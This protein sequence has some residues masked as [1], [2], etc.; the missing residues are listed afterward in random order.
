[1]VCFEQLFLKKDEDGLTDPSSIKDLS[2]RVSKATTMLSVGRYCFTIIPIFSRKMDYRG[3]I[4]LILVNKKTNTLGIKLLY[5]NYAKVNG[6]TGEQAFLLTKNV[7]PKHKTCLFSQ[8]QTQKMITDNVLRY[9]S[10]K[11]MAHIGHAN[12]STTEGYTY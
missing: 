6:T 8:H 1:M 7:R 4:W 2:V 5:V 11:V 3:E 10:A 9:G 12:I